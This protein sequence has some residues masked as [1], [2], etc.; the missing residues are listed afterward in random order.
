MTEAPFIQAV[1]P[2]HVIFS[3]GHKH[4]HPRAS[5]AQRYLNNSVS[6][7]NIFRT[8]RGDN[9][10]GTEWNHEATS[11][12]DSVGDDDVEIEISASGTLTV[13]YR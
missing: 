4:H 11:S 8:D 13:A 1:S 12:S 2:S 6:L 7:T 3:A 5:A 9:E 10:G